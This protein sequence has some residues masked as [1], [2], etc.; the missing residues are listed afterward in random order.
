MIW[1]TMWHSFSRSF[2]NLLTKAD[3]HVLSFTDKTTLSL[4]TVAGAALPGLPT[5]SILCNSSW[6]LVHELRNYTRLHRWLWTGM[7]KISEMFFWSLFFAIYSIIDYIYSLCC[8]VES[9]Y[10]LWWRRFLCY[11]C[12][13][14]CLFLCNHIFLQCVDIVRRFVYF[15]S[16]TL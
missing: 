3:A 5:W 13:Y 11:I 4:E 9:G 12:L 14:M 6:R 8:L 10:M 15:F 1:F 16:R 7:R 2:P